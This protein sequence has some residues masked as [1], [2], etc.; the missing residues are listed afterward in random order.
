MMFGRKDNSKRDLAIGTAKLVEVK[1]PRDKLSDKQSVWID[2]L[3][4]GG[5]DVEVLYVREKLGE[6]EE[7]DS[8]DLA[9]GALGAIEETLLSQQTV[10]IY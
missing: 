3:A 5:V 4:N 9:M 2:T 1:G 8:L 6:G 7:D 10:K